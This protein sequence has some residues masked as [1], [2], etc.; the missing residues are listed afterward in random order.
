MSGVAPLLTAYADAALALDIQLQLQLNVGQVIAAQV[1]A[2]QN[3]QDLIELLGQQIPAQL[4]SGVYPG[5]TLLLQVTGF[6]SN[7]ILVRNLGLADASGAQ[8]A[9]LDEVLLEAAA[10]PQV[11]PALPQPSAGQ[12]VPAQPAPAQAAPA[13][14]A[15][16]TVSRTAPVQPAP[17]QPAPA[18][19]AAAQTTA[20]PPARVPNAPAPPRAVFVAASIRPANLP[21]SPQGQVPPAP[22]APANPALLRLEARIAAAQTAKS[23]AAAP[24]PGAAAPRAASERVPQMAPR[25]APAAP[26][27]R[28]AGSASAL[29]R[30]VTNRIANTITE[31][32][33]A[34]RLPDTPLTRTAAAIAKQAPGRLPSVLARLDA[35]LPAQTSDARIPSLRAILAFVSRL[36]P[37]NE[38]TLP[39]QISA[40]VSH[41]VQGSESKLLQLVAAVKQLPL[42]A[43]GDRAASSTLNVPQQG[44]ASERAAAIQY[45]LKSIVLSL[46]RNPPA[47]RTPALTQALNETLVTLTGTQIGVLSSNA[48]NPGSIAFGL[49]L[50]FREGGK[51]VQLRVSRDGGGG[52]VPM[53]ADNFHVAFLLDTAHLGTVAIDLQ[54]TGRSVQVAVKTERESQAK[55]FVSTLDALRARLEQLRYRVASA[56]AAVA[57]RA[58]PA[59]DGASQTEQAPVVG[60]N[61]IDMQA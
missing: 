28:A 17:V 58:M 13:Q 31:V 59:V 2:P 60:S 27:P 38:E 50:M 24:A 48:Q 37:Q 52:R 40:Y 32:L 15:V 16:L 39:A 5:E 23:A 51:P 10:A 54:T 22:Q 49:P 61:G 57:A 19:P 4:P 14:S 41:V 7:Q 53:D 26:V 34:L 20:S 42:D 12:S 36:A 11:A 21:P 30:G 47:Q 9:L 25:P 8:S 3:G 55:R 29:A 44:R 6:T 56:S 43:T 45:D 18:Q 33:R 46:L 1:L 35:A